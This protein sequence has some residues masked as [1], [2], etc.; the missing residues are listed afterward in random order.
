MKDSKKNITLFTFSIVLGLLLGTTIVNAIGVDIDPRP[1][2]GFQWEITDIQTIDGTDYYLNE[3]IDIRNGGEL[4]ILNSNFYINASSLSINVQQ[5]GL[6]YVDNSNITVTNP[7]YTYTADTTQPLIGS[8]YTF[9]DSHVVNARISISQYQEK[10][11]EFVST[12]TTFEEFGLFKLQNVRYIDIQESTFYNSTVGVEIVNGHDVQIHQNTFQML[13]YGLDIDDS[14]GGALSYNNFL[15]ITETGLIIDDFSRTNIG[16]LPQVEIEWNTF[17][18]MVTGAIL[19]DSRLHF[20]NNDMRNLE[21]ALFLEN[22]DFGNYEYNNFTAIADECIVAVDTRVTYIQNNYFAHSHTAINLDYSPVIIQY[23]SFENFTSGIIGYDSDGLHIYENDFNNIS[24][25]AMEVDETRDVEINTN[26]ISNSLGGVF[27]TNG[28][29]SLIQENTLNTVEDGIAIVYC[30]DVS[31]LGNT[32]N[33]TVSGYYIETTRD[34]VLTANGAINAEYGIS[35]WS[36]TD[37]VLASNGVFDSVYGLSIWFSDFIELAGNDVSTSDIGIVGRNTYGLRIRD[38]SYTLLT[39][40]IQ[41]LGCTLARI[42]G[43]TFDNIVEE[44]I[45]LS[46]SYDFVV[47]NNNF[48]TVGDYGAIDNS[49]GT[50]Y[51]QIDNETYLGNYYFGLPLTPVLIDEFTVDLVT[52]NITDYYPLAARYNVRPSVEFLERDIYEPTDID[53]VTITTQVFI[54]DGTEDVEVYLHYLLVNETNWRVVD[55]TSSETQIGSIGAISQ[56]QST[57]MPLPYDFDVVY[58]IMVNFTIDFV[59]Y[60]VFSLN[61]TYHVDESDFTPIVIGTPEVRVE[62]YN[63]AADSFSTVVTNNFYEDLEYYVFVSVKNRTNLQIVAGKRHVNLSW[64]EIDPTTNDT[65]YFSGIM[66]YN[67]SLSPMSYYSTFGRGYAIGMELVFFITVVDF[68]GT[69]YRTVLNFTM[70]IQPPVQESGFGTIT[71]LSLGATLLLVQVIVV[72]RRRKA[73]EE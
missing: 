19:E 65:Q 32:V 50:F 2:Y 8:N 38:G 10:F 23:N 24:Y 27:L 14:A 33:N 31:V 26:S 59:E 45:T 41:L 5:G 68:D 25:Y 54:P 34:I 1:D 51:R 64:Y 73:K 53:P 40:G 47:Y 71:L 49:Y 44:A 57:I 58:R 35:L 56:F 62:S 28:R 46:D 3:N 30:R 69:I 15:D 37:A 72:L 67:S 61:G 42:I 4:R 7:S 48:L 12:R 20:I 36:V 22:S 29:N 21:N 11:C 43:N 18:N 17:D 70:T 39:K 66:D 6:L 60:S 52:Y 13:D 55:I 63:E 16:G 9:V